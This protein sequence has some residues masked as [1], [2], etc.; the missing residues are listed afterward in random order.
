MSSVF[1]GLARGASI[2][3]P[4][5]PA[6]GPPPRLA[7]G[8]PQQEAIWSAICEGESHLVVEARAGTGKSSTCREGMHRLL[9]ADRSLSGRL[10][11]VAF[12]RSI[13]D[14]FQAG[15]PAG[16]RATTMHAAGFAALKAALPGLGEPDRHKLRGIADRLLSGRDRESRKTKT[17]AVRLAEACKS[18]LLGR[19]AR[20]Q[21]YGLDAGTLCRLAS[22]HGIDVRG[23]EHA[24][25]T[26]VPE[27]L[28]RALRQ[29]ASVD[30]GD[31]VWMPVMLELDFPE[32]EVLFVDEAQDLDPCQ[33]ALVSM[34]TGSGRIVIVGDPRQAIYGFR[35]ADSRSMGTL[36]ELFRATARGLDRLPLTATRR[37]PAS[38]VRLARNI[39][40]DFESLPVA[41]GGRWEEGVELAD[42]VAP[43][44]MV[45]CRKNAPLL[46]AAFKLVGRGV[47]VAIQGRDLGEGLA[48][49][50][51]D[52][53][54]SGV[55][56][57]L[58][59]M[60]DYR[61]AQMERL[62]EVDDS[63]EE[64]ELV[65]DRCDCVRAV[66]AGC[67]TPVDVANRVRSL[68]KEVTRAE[69]SECVLFS[70]I[71]RAKG[72]EAENVAI[73]EPEGMPSP[74]AR[75]PAAIEQ[76][77]NLLYVA[78]TRSK[79]RMSFLGPVP[80]PLIGA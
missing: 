29:T 33:H 28:N 41:P 55:A 12:N 21:R 38:H 40:P 80:P 74:F 16:A 71:H 53:E 37:C 20:S 70:S 49:F 23:R 45:L 34:M 11:Y 73:L 72:R 8:S 2:A 35:G 14:E 13:A 75:S 67:Q 43:G 30:F 46:S 66:A 32:A 57:L 22:A 19:D 65:N 10:A 64:A 3:P 61:A 6:P 62:S 36:S 17:C 15:L 69:Q 59:K 42:V 52:F 25:A 50:V 78:A 79:H 7:R 51:E 60:A 27:M 48:R 44:W 24:L 58:R 31:M 68:F 4:A 77:L 1:A 76:E 39:V 47:P 56:E 5:A 18:Q 26:M 54:A 9:G 63:E